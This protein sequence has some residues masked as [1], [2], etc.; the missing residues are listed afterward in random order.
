MQQHRQGAGRVRQRQVEVQTA[1][2]GPVHRPDSQGKN[3][4]AQQPGSWLVGQV[5][6][7]YLPDERLT[8]AVGC[9][10]RCEAEYNKQEL[11]RKWQKIKPDVRAN[12]QVACRGRR[13]AGADPSCPHIDTQLGRQ[14]LKR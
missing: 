3:L 12:D 9:V 14:W 2:Q 13:G 1:R 10:T 7:K 8:A 5:E 6:L 11:N 4:D